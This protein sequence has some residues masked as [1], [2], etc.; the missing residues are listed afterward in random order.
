LVLVVLAVQ[1]K[2]QLTQTETMQ[3]LVEI[4]HLVRY[5]LAMVVVEVKVEVLRLVGVKPLAVVA[6]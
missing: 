4:L 6:L 2:Q 5:K 3:L 1:H